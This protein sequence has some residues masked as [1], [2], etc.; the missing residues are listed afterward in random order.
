MRHGSATT[1]VLV[2]H[3]DQ[4]A[5]FGAAETGVLSALADDIAFA[6]DSART[7]AAL[8]QSEERLS[9]VIEHTPDV[10]IQWY[11]EQGRVLF[12]NEASRRLFQ[13][14]E[15][16]TLGKP[17][18]SIGFWD[19]SEEARFAA[20]RARARAGGR[21]APTEFCFRRADGSR[22]VLLST[23]FEIPLSEVEHCYVC[24]DVDIT[25][26]RNMEAAVRAGEQLRALI[27]DSVGDVLFC[28]AVE[29]G[30]RYRF[31]SVNRAFS[32]ATGLAESEVVGRLVDD[33]IPA[34]SLSLAKEKYTEAISS[35]RKVVWEEVSHHPKGIRYGEVSVSPIFHA[36]GACSQLV[37]SVH[38]M[39]ERR[40]AERAQREIEAQLH[41]AQRLQALGTLA[42]G[43]AH[44]FNN[45]LAAIHGNLDFTLSAHDV[46]EE[47]REAL[48]EVKRAA[49]R[50]TSLVRRILTF[51]RKSEPRH[52]LLELRPVIDE[53]LKL[54]SVTLKGVKLGSRFASD[55]PRIRGDSTQI[56]QVI[57]NLVTNAVQAIGD[58]RGRVDVSLEACV[59]GAGGRSDA[60]ELTPGRYVRLTIEDD[61]PGMDEMTLRRAF[62]P[63]FTTKPPGVGTGLGLSVVHGIVKSHQG[64][65]AV[66]SAPRKG[67]TFDLYF[68]ASD[69]SPAAVPNRNERTRPRV[70]F[71]DDDEA[72]V[73]LA[74]R[75]FAHLGHEVSAHS[76]SREALEEFR[77][78]PTEFD[79]VV[80]DIAMPVLD[81]P[82]LIRELR[83]IRP[84]IAIVCTSG[85]I[86]LEDVAAAT[87]LGVAQL[88]DKPQSI[89]DLAR[90]VQA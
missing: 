78:R 27:Y 53:A 50:A 18:V 68:P 73:F 4:P 74:R 38:D 12:Y 10:A 34:T 30:G 70:L 23:V 36:D 61:G 29:G 20:A 89:D 44:D 37:G 9:A 79:V 84:E 88:L 26:Q 14:T 32:E 72:I 41:Q 40:E 81:G 71:V 57:L 85:C 49:E 8:R 51:G 2:L 13:W 39:T 6:A 64:A 55:L 75:A 86:R 19:A 33:V 82:A 35:R 5:A 48:V 46:G 17:L 3:S 21:V 47:T 15:T 69:D 54:M 43:I 87:E 28:L 56:H 67:T 59:V 90:L 63:F 42:G 16:S 77:R 22:G 31:Q 80:T 45:I 60:P 1:G 25:E 65:I 83:G 62:E 66:R 24:M 11:D 52:E 76:S 58:A 7:L